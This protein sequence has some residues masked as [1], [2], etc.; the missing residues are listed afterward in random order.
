MTNESVPAHV[1]GAF[2]WSDDLIEPISGGLINQTYRV[3]RAGV[4]HAVIQKL[5]PIFAG[6]VNLDLDAITTYLAKLGMVTPRL[7]RTRD[8]APW[9]DHEGRV[10]RALSYVEGV[11][12]HKLRSPERARA[13]GQLVG[14]FHAALAPLR[15]EYAFTRAGVHDTPAHFARLREALTRPLPPDAL[16][17]TRSDLVHQARELGREILSAGAGLPDLAGL[18]TRH[19]HGDLKI[20]NVLFSSTPGETR[21]LC[22]VDLDTLGRQTIAYELGDALRSWCNTGGEDRDRARIDRDILAAAMDGYQSTENGLL[23]EAEWHSIIPGLQTICLEL[24]A[25]F[26]VDVFRDEYFGWNPARFASRREHNLVRARGQLALARSVA[27]DRDAL[28]AAIA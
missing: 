2:G 21:A 20:S 4:P 16:P 13:A 24:S 28:N 12:V 18:P 26:C 1:I 11:T 19:C 8:G 15:H 9:V 17:E 3:S 22:L 7:L 27:A 10:W 14:R 6:P 23:D 25:R 5:H